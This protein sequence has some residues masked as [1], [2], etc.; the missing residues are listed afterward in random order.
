MQKIGQL[1]RALAFTAAVGGLT[2][3]A[4]LALA[5]AQ[6]DGYAGKTEAEIISSLESQGYEVRKVEEEDGYLEAYVLLDGSRFE[7]Y[8][9]PRSGRIVEIEADD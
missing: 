5:A 3:A 1:S 6:E 8:V 4:G 9:D 7:I 2:A